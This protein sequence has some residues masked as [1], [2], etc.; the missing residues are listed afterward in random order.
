MPM[1]QAIEVIERNFLAGNLAELRVKL[2][3]GEDMT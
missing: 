2:S 1:Q 3:G